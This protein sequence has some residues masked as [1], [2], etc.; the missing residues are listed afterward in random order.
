[1]D[2]ILGATGVGR[3]LQFLVKWKDRDEP[4]LVSSDEAK[5]KYPYHVLDF[6]E[7]CLIW[8]SDDEAD[9]DNDADKTLK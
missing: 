4:T 5:T 9:E 6:Y 7:S 2:K 8:E 1:M 3:Q